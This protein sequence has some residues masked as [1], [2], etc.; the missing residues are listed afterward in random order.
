MTAYNEP[1]YQHRLLEEPPASIILTINWSRVDE[2][3]FQIISYY[4]QE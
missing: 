3:D 2:F 4:H 1:D